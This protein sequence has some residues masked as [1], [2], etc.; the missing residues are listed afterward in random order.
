MLGRRAERNGIQ[1]RTTKFHSFGDSAIR[2]STAS[3]LRNLR[4]R[5]RVTEIHIDSRR[6]REILVPRHFLTLIAGHRIP[7]ELRQ[8]LHLHRE[9][10]RNPIRVAVVRDTNQHREPGRPLHQ[11][12]DL[13]RVRLP[14]DQVPLPETRHRQILGL[15]RPL[16]DVH[17]VPDL[18]LTARGT[19]PVDAWLFPAAAPA[20]ARSAAHRGP[21]GTTSDRSSRGTPA[22][23]DRRDELAHH[24]DPENEQPDTHP[25]RHSARSPEKSSNDD[26]PSAARYHAPNTPARYIGK[27]APAPQQSMPEIRSHN[28]LPIGRRNPRI[29]S[30]CRYDGLTPSRYMATA[31]PHPSTG[32][33]Y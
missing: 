18:P 19:R 26:D 1:F 7:D 9:E 2:C 28:T 20:S 6:D 33:S 8:L 13:R 11:G 14:D 16:A 27:S 23:P 12:R 25:H 10:P 5:M 29:L 24:N 17:H 32:R 4:R 21:A 30:G 22:S 3:K 31:E 15:R